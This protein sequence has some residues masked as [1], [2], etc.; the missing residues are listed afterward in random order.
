L[1]QVDEFSKF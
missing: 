1:F